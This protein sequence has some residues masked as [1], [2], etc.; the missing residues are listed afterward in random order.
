MDVLAEELDLKLRTWA[1]ETA[2]AV[3]DGVA[4]LIELA[5]QDV[6]DIARLRD[7]EQEVLDILDEPASR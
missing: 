4:E 1:P 5:D 2:A 7:R 3:R 6:L